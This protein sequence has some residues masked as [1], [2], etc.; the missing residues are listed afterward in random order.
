MSAVSAE[1]RA[2]TRERERR[3]GPVSDWASR[4][5]EGAAARS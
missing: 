1:R 5:E 4:E 3:A 2:K